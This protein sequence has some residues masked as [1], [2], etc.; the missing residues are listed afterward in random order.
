[1]K[2]I[3]Y[4]II[5]LIFGYFTLYAEELKSIK[6]V[7]YLTTN[8]PEKIIEN[9]RKTAETSDGFVKYFD[10]K[11][12]IIKIPSNKLNEITD[13]IKKNAFIQDTII[14]SKNLSEDLLSTKTKLKIKKD[15]LKKLYK[16]F[17][18]SNIVQTI[19]VE[20]EVNDYITQMEYLEGRIRF[21]ENQISFNELTIY[22]NYEHQVIQP[23][24]HASQWDWINQLG[25]K[26]LL[27][28]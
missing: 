23:K 9:L 14:S 1:M 22:I 25:L 26:Q 2:K 24:V 13:E 21:L 10:L 16:I 18:T 3:V 4:V 11:T 6:Y 7:Y 27:S 12:I 5:I 19:D 8:F 28:H 15:F 17:E 20:K